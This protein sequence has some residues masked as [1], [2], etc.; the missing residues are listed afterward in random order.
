MKTKSFLLLT[1][2]LLLPAVCFGDKFSEGIQA[3]ARRDK[4]LQAAFLQFK[5]LMPANG[6]GKQDFQ[7]L[8]LEN[9]VKIAG[10]DYYGFRFTVPQR[11][12]HEDLVWA[13]MQPNAPFTGWYI[14]PQTGD[15]VDGVQAQAGAG[16]G[17]VGFED[18]LYYP[19]KDYPEL[20]NLSP[21]AG[22]FLV[23]QHLSGDSLEDGKEYIIWFSFKSEKK[24]N[25]ISLEFEFAKLTNK[26]AQNRK[27]ME[28]VLGLHRGQP[29]TDASPSTD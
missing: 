1:T 18:Y 27:V 2:C 19:R 20:H 12:S 4:Q 21:T 8:K 15:T 16:R 28:K 10:A 3:G 5:E 7:K 13:F 23:L 22:K 17:F 26:D 6:S 29:K 11:T 25:W 14:L 9:P 24:P